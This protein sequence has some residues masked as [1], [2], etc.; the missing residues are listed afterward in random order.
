MKGYLDN[1][2]L[3]QCDEGAHAGNVDVNLTERILVRVFM[4]GFV[5]LHDEIPVF[6]PLT[7][8]CWSTLLKVDGYIAL[9]DISSFY[10]LVYF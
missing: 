2:L 10:Y 1:I 4:A 5:V 9:F 7:F 3:K 6:L 8:Q